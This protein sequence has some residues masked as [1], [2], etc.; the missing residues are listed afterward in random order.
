MKTIEEIDDSVIIKDSSKIIIDRILPSG[1]KLYGV[2][3]ITNQKKHFI[4]PRPIYHHRFCEDGA[5]SAGH[6]PTGEGIWWFDERAERR[7]GQ[8]CAWRVGGVYQCTF[9]WFRYH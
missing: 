9:L 1:I 2:K 3:N 5:G 8:N 4:K 7:P 6:L